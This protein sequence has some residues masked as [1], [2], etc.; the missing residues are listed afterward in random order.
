MKSKTQSSND[1]GDAAEAA[2]PKVIIDSLS[3]EGAK[4]S[5]QVV[6]FD[7][8]AEVTPVLVPPLKLLGIGRKEQGVT[9]QE[10][11][12]QV[13]GPFVQSA[14]KAAGNAGLYEGLSADVLKDMGMGTLNKF[15]EDAS[16]LGE[17]IGSGIKSLFGN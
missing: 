9:V 4:V 7:Q 5:P 14:S 17:S 11:V 2:G 1:N 16:A 6:L 12:V 10:A 3:I 8:G 15:K 13:I